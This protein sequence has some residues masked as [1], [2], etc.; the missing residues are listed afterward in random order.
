MLTLPLLFQVLKPVVSAAGEG[1]T[2][3]LEFF[4]RR[5][6]ML[7]YVI[8]SAFQNQ[9]G[10]TFK[11]LLTDFCI[12]AFSS[13]ACSSTLH[14]SFAYVR[15]YFFLF[16]V[17]PKPRVFHLHLHFFNWTFMNYF[18]LWAFQ[19]QNYAPCFIPVLPAL[20][21]SSSQGLSYCTYQGSI[22]AYYITVLRAVIVTHR[23][24]V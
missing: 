7:M 4:I 16:F 17:T 10:V 12:F 13:L 23:I 1:N 22:S 8:S 20:C 15:Y 5:S 2:V 3:L 11:C 19:C 9:L 21:V 6:I 24:N 14:L 18:Y